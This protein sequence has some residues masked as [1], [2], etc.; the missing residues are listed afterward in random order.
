[1][2]R[3][4]IDIRKIGDYGIGTYIRNLLKHLN[5]INR[6][7]DFILF[8]SPGADLSRLPKEMSAVEEKS[9]LYSIREPFSLGR[10]ARRA[11]LQL[12]HCPHYVTP[13]FPGCPL[14]VTVHDLIHLLFPEQLPNRL[15]LSYSRFFLKRAAKKA[16]VIFAVSECT[17]RDI[18]NHLP[19]KEERVVVTYNAVDP[20]MSRSVAEEE[21]RAV[22]RRFG[23]GKPYILYTGN[24]K[25]HKNLKK[26]IEAFVLFLK[27]ADTKLEF[28]IVGIDQP[29]DNLQRLIESLK[30]KDAIRFLGFVPLKELPA[31]YAQ[32]ELFL[33][34]SL[35]EG[36]GLPP[37]EAMAAG[38]AVV[39]SDRG[40]L[41]EVLGDAAS[42]VDP[43][44]PQAM[45][46]AMGRIICDS[47]LRRQ[48]I[49]RGLRQ[50]GKYSWERTAE[51]TLDG[52]RLA[53]EAA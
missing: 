50:V 38:T 8:H 31:I 3:I 27:T 51:K 7:H 19:A 11:G 47:R 10:S 5:S 42:L 37:L 4:G 33:F 30:I 22:R 36:F 35:Y 9:G 20:L 16:A 29:D 43:L 28:V 53:L 45:A 40:A 21:G 48:L 18:L 46:A 1:M 49:E 41:P 24:L 44:N 15:A 14:A 2:A 17:S 25:P 26:A 39:A 13:F 32:A 12:L 6:E 34:P 52:Y 23:L